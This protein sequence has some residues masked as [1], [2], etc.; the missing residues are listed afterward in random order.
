MII[1]QFHRCISNKQ[2]QLRMAWQRARHGHSDDQLWSLNYALAKL[3]VVGVKRMRECRNGYP[4]EFAP[5]PHGDGSGWEAWDKILAEIEEGFQAWLDA[6]GWFT[7]KPEQEA[8]FKRAIKL[9]QKWFDAL[10]N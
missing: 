9:F 8:K 3:I 6:D 2:F 4:A 1:H 7:G 10:W 5:P